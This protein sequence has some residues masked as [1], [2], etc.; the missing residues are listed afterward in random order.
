VAVRDRGLGGR[1]YDPYS[2]AILFRRALRSF[3]EVPGACAAS[4]P[5]ERGTPS[6]TASALRRPRDR[7]FAMRTQWSLTKPITDPLNH[8]NICAAQPPGLSTKGDDALQGLGSRLQGRSAY[9]W[10]RFP[11]TKPDSIGLSERRS[12]AGLRQ[13]SDKASTSR[14]S[15]AWCR[16]TENNRPHRRVQQARK[17]SL[18]TAAATNIVIVHAH[19]QYHRCVR[20][21]LVF[22]VKEGE[23]HGPSARRLRATSCFA[24]V[25]NGRVFAPIVR[26]EAIA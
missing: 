26:S 13:V 21:R 10:P 24:R 2:I 3:W 22:E 20:P 19:S 7:S 15:P 17:S 18:R 9:P 25:Q 4:E 11:N 5:H 12:L 23:A 1:P 8:D 6:R 14:R 16:P